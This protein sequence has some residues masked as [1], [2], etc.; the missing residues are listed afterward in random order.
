MILEI[1]FNSDE[2]LYIQLRNQI[3]I[4]IATSQLSAGDSLPSVRQLADR[5]GIICSPSL[6]IILYSVQASSVSPEGRTASPAPFVWHQTLSICYTYCNTDIIK[7][8]LFLHYL[9]FPQ[10]DTDEPRR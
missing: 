10:S 6:M 1:D 9:F 3:V 5:V 2:A 7:I 4:G 8:N